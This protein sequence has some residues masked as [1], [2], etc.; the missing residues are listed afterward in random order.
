MRVKA[1]LN[2]AG[3]VS[4]YRGEVRECGDEAAVADLIRAGYVELE[5]MEPSG[6]DKKPPGEEKGGED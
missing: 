1:L 2:F 5:Q 3:V 4:M 6:T